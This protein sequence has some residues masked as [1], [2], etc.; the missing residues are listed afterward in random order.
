VSEPGVSSD[1]LARPS[2]AC[3][4]CPPP[5]GRA[6][7][8][9][10]DRFA[11]CTS[12]YDRLRTSLAEIAE[13]YL[14]LD[15]RPGAQ[16]ESGSR[17]A[18]GFGSRPP[19]SVHVICLKDP[20]SSQDSR[21]WLGKDGRVH[22]EEEHPPLSVH[23]VL[24]TLCWE[25][26]EHRGVSGPGDRDDVYAL[27]KFIDRSTDHVT[28]HAE[29]AVEV[30]TQLRD[31]VSALRPLTGDRRR[32]IGK[33]PRPAPES[34]QPCRCGR[35]SVQ[36]DNDARE[37]R[38]NEFH[39]DCPAFVPASDAE[40]D[41]RCGAGR[42]AIYAEGLQGEAFPGHHPVVGSTASDSHVRQSA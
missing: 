41:L 22:R 15:P 31:L 39:C 36:H 5:R 11:T 17:G 35:R 6:W 21:V 9:A 10:D 2:G 18:P 26:A 27:L 29:L 13:R 28:R 4:T 30:D 24:S 7:T 34:E 37:C 33:C 20:R 16:Y 25:I 23:G 42:R 12:C 40:E 3:V 19:A 8:R 38:C 14:R 32:R 1:P